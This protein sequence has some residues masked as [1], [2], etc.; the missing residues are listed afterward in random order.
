MI[1]GCIAQMKAYQA[2]SVGT[3]AINTIKLVDKNGQ[4]IQTLDRNKLWEVQTPQCFDYEV[5]FKLH[6]K[7]DKAG[8]DD[9]T[10]DCTLAERAGLKVKMLKGNYA[11]IKI[12]V[13][14]DLVTAQSILK[15]IKR[16]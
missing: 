16:G 5:L 4:V 9:I 10:D 3:A 1:D 2:C 8:I 14:Q 6:K 7:A 11:N 15:T 13:A 12:T